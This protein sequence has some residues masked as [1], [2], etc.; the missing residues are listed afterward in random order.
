M[1]Q[2]ERAHPVCI[3]L[4]A[5][6][7]YVCSS[8]PFSTEALWL[9]EA[10]W[11]CYLPLLAMLDRLRN[12]GVACHITVSLSPTL[13]SM[14]NDPQ[15]RDDYANY[16]AALLALCDAERRRAPHRGAAI[17]G[18]SSRIERGQW[19]QEAGELEARWTALSTD[20]GVELMT[21]SASHAYLPALGSVAGAVEA[22]LAIGRAAFASQIGADSTS[23][24]LPECAFD[25][26]VGDA[27][28]QS[29][30]QCTVLDAHGTNG[31]SRQKNRDVLYL[32]RDAA[33]S[34]QV[35]ARRGGFPGDAAYR[36][37]H[38]DVSFE[39]TQ[40]ELQ[41]FT[42]GRM[43]GVKLWAISGDVYDPDRADERAHQHARQFV[44]S[45]EQRATQEPFECPL[46]AAYDA[47]LFGHWWFEGVT[48]LEEA[49]RRIAES[50]QVELITLGE[51]RARVKVG[52]SAIPTASSWGAGG[53]GAAWVGPRCA[54]LWR[55][56][57]NGQ[58][59]VRLA[60]LRDERRADA[61]REQLL[62]ESSDWLFMLSGGDGASYARHRCA[63]H[64]RNIGRIVNGSSYD[65]SRFLSTLDD[66]ELCALFMDRR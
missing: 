48:F 57:H 39:R 14:W 24:W 9:N 12:D 41:P 45:L 21:T 54:H 34:R 51:A 50:E 13:L 6:L 28:H 36:E 44:R 19:P 60:P 25:E 33:T 15:L 46:V 10:M 47:E 3:V 66:S 64:V 37:F 27:L 1:S 49:L 43:S 18:L 56:I 29:G 65:R 63:E 11:E 62:L 5:H 23:M 40:S 42:R 8:A 53:Y 59:R 2:L 22:Q 55:H 35:W 30:V 61:I 52:Q 17:D 58:Q 7:P 26:A 31:A 20:A 16:C 38:C 4:H 32:P